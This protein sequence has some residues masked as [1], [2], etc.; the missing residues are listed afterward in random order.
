[1]KLTAMTH[2]GFS[3]WHVVNAAGLM[4]AVSCAACGA[5]AQD[6]A[7]TADELSSDARL[8]TTRS[9]VA[10]APITKRKPVPVT[11]STSSSSSGTSSSSSSSSSS[12]GAVH[13]LGMGSPQPRSAGA[14]PR[15]IAS[16]SVAGHDELVIAQAGSSQLT[17]L[18]GGASGPTPGSTY[19][20]GYAV[21][22]AAARGVMVTADF[23]QGR[24]SVV[25][26]AGAT[27][28]TIVTRGGPTRVALVDEDAVVGHNGG[29]IVRISQV[30]SA[31]PTAIELF[32]AYA[33]IGDLVAADVDGDSFTDVV[34]TVPEFS[35]V[36]MLPANGVAISWNVMDYPDRVLV[37]DLTGDGLPDLVVSHPH[38][39]AVYLYAR[40]ADGTLAAAELL[41]PGG[42]AFALADFDRDGRT[43]LIT[44]NALG[45]IRVQ[46][47]ARNPTQSVVGST[48]GSVSDLTMADLN[49]DGRLDIAAILPS[50]GTVVWF[51]NA[52]Y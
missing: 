35:Q 20:V 41:G 15:A 31:N 38:A 11:T 30:A 14:E 9:P 8:P 22:V 39:D 32:N 12:G 1:M 43:D 46:S 40:N 3:G 4:L 23:L 27:P 51:S 45:V 50:S 13:A 25:A 10:L 19:A 17:T 5:D 44:A 48:N 18:V 33:R 28:T 26:S 6:A 16:Y 7:D 47:P 24:V 36:G 34:Y 21:S 52:S 37:K 42:A 2:F 49:A 29:S